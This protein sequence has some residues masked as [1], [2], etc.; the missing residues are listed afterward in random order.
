VKQRYVRP[1]DELLDDD[2]VVR[3][4][5]LDGEEVIEDALTVLDIYGIYALSVFA[6]RS[7][8]LDEMAQQPPLVRY[9]ELTLVRAGEISAV[10]LRLVPSG[11]RPEHFA[12]EF[13]D[14]DDGLDRLR[15]CERWSE[16]NPYHVS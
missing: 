2:I 5:P 6:V 9:P 11:R 13:D 3:G 16:L 7:A 1:N 14:L 10:G 4:G 12:I 15:T 8:T